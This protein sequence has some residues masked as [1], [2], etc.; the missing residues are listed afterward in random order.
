MERG[1]KDELILKRG[2]LARVG[3]TGPVIRESDIEGF[4]EGCQRCRSERLFYIQAH[5]S[6]SFDWGPPN[7]KLAEGCLPYRFGLGGNDDLEMVFC[8][9]CGQI[10]GMWPLPPGVEDLEQDE[11]DKP[12]SWNRPNPASRERGKP[13]KKKPSME[14]RFETEGEEIVEL[15]L[16]PGAERIFVKLGFV[17]KGEPDDDGRPVW[18][19]TEKGAE[20][21]IGKAKRLS[22][23]G[24][25]Q[26]PAGSYWSE[27]DN[28]FIT[29]TED[30]WSL[31]EFNDAADSENSIA[32]SYPELQLLMTMYKAGGAEKT[33]IDRT[34]LA[35][36]LDMYKGDVSEILQ[37]ME[38]DGLVVHVSVTTWSLSDV[39]FAVG[40]SINRHV[41]RPR[42]SIESIENGLLVLRAL[43]VL[44]GKASSRELADRLGCTPKEVKLV[45]EELANEH[46]IIWQPLVEDDDGRTYASFEMK[47]LGRMLLAVVG[48]FGEMQRLGPGEPLRAPPELTPRQEKALE[49]IVELNEQDGQSGPHGTTIL[50]E[51]SSVSLPTLRR[52]L[53][54]LL[55]TGLVVRDI[56]GDAQ[57]YYWR[58]SKW[59]E[60]MIDKGVILAGSLGEPPSVSVRCQRVLEVLVERHYL[61]E[62]YCYESDVATDMVV[63]SKTAR[64]HLNE[65]QKDGLVEETRYGSGT[66]KLATSAKR[67][68]AAG[69]LP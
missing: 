55:E 14:E 44:G 25:L 52:G 62:K 29:P 39:G 65:L 60:S 50:A 33:T 11:E 7:G 36:L 42:S 53:N 68:I 31:A 48:D 27:A 46:L 47:P 66:W 64:R 16:P 45:A 10:Q 23:S 2:E 43:Q 67:W 57:N 21:L 32:L 35:R 19:L 59:A 1:D 40:R 20:A 34:E 51:Q 13:R 41:S 56:E 69:R 12:E 37:G 6:S 26:P 8:L 4:E 9:N 3:H 63:Q 49:A 58:L 61:G 15:N 24:Q 54:D 30:E 5:A 22:S 28:R 38:Q 17:E 18:N